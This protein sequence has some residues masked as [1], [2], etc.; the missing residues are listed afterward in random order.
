MKA[1]LDTD[2]LLRHDAKKKPHRDTEKLYA[3]LDRAGYEKCIVPTSASVL[4]TQA[5][6]KAGSYSVEDGLE[7]SAEVASVWRRLDELGM[8]RVFA[9]ILDQLYR[10]NVDIVISEDTG[11]YLMAQALGVSERVFNISAFLEKCFS[12]HP[13]WVDYRVLSVR[14]T[15]FKNID[16]S[17]S[18]FDTLKESYAEFKDWFQRKSEEYAYVSIYNGKIIAFLYLKVEDE[19]EDYTGMNPPF[20]PCTR[21]KIGTFKVEASG[22][23]LGERFLKIVFDNALQFKVDEVYVTIFDK[24]DETRRLM[25]TLQKWGFVQYG[26]KIGENGTELVYTRSMTR[27]YDGRN[28]L[29]TY[30]FVSRQASAFLIPIYPSYHTDLLPDSLLKNECASDFEDS[31]PHRNALSKIYISRSI[32][33]EARRGDLLVFYRTGGY[34]AAVTTTIGIVEE[35]VTDI[36]DEADFIRKCRKRSVFTDEELSKHWN[37]NPNMR[38]FIIKFLYAYTFPKRMNMRALIDAGV[39]KDTNSAPRGLVPLTH[40]QFCAILD[41]SGTSPAI[42]AD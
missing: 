39:I 14:R 12:E 22:F 10:R 19:N 27:R 38:P 7:L 42:I 29:N 2:I 21:M 34:H 26:T 4:A 20:R 23:R 35:V 9:E 1:I 25:Q 37:Y 31:E 17:D 28:P 6:K 8:H 24:D 5:P 32:N 36:A 3:W 16:L 15:Q 41:G 33:K 11:L 30:P 40:Q 13:E 18:F